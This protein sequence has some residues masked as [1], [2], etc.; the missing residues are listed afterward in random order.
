MGTILG[1]PTVTNITYDLMGTYDGYPTDVC[2][3]TKPMNTIVI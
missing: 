1:K 2:W 3:F